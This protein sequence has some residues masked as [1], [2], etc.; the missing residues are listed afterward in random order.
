MRI[1]VT[2]NIDSEGKPFL[3]FTKIL[4]SGYNTVIG[5]CRPYKLDFE[6]FKKNY[7]GDVKSHQMVW[8]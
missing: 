8:V 5:T 7:L 2:K 1:E 3:V 4:K 6:I